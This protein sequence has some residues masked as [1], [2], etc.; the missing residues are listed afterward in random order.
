M[1][2]KD[3]QMKKAPDFRTRQKFPETN[4][5]LKQ[6]RLF[7]LGMMPLVRQKLRGAVYSLRSAVDAVIALLR[8]VSEPRRFQTAIFMAGSLAVAVFA[9]FNVL[10]TTATT[11]MFDGVE[12]ATVSSEEEAQA[13]R[14]SV[15]K[16][17]SDVLGYEYTVE[18]SLVS[19]STGVTP[20]SSVDDAKELEDALSDTL[21]MVEHGYA[22][23]V[24]GQMIGATQT[25]GAFEELLEQLA[26]PYTNENTVSID[27]VEEVE[28]VECDLSVDAF[29]NLADVALLL[30]STKAGE[31]HYT[32]QAGD[33]WS[34]I[35]QD[36]DMGSSEL[37][38]LN[39]G[40]DIDKL[41]IGDVLL[42]SNAVPYLTVVVTQMEYYVTDVP[43]DIDYVDD[44]SMWEGDTRV[45]S[46]GAY[47]TADV[48]ALVT[49]QGSVEV[50]RQVQTQVI[51]T[52]PVTEI[53]AR[54]TTPRPS[55]APTGTFRW[56]TNGTLTS[57]F[58]YR[59]IFGSRSFHGGID[60]ANSRGTDIVASDGGKVIYA[61]WQGAYGYLIKIDHLNG[62]TTY[63]GHC[64]KLLVS[65]G[66]YVHKGQHIAE[67][68]STGRSTGSHLHFEVRYNNERQD[69]QKYLP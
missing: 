46:K 15:E 67:M 62:Y 52:Q 8:R 60:I 14:M 51:I 59:Y 18:D 29:T 41:Q 34:Q 31:V 38:A 50:D 69:P 68:G 57:P 66:D 26:A 61:G 65:V 42:I 3:K 45:L 30:N 36:H 27:F 2:S 25:E 63:Y 12:L 19:Y 56:P 32:V 64:S 33:C 28:I 23:F 53:Q 1:P 58:G 37:L 35:A 40:Y 5:Y 11:V 17:I 20:R 10:Y 48:S 55:W 6:L 16:H 24:N 13:V 7:F 54:G 44:E 22:L 49:Y 9:V 21:R 39:P 47:G 4:S 43:Y